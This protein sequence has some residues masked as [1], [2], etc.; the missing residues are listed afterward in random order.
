MTNCTK[1]I[2]SVTIDCIPDCHV[3]AGNYYEFNL[4][5]LKWGSL[6]TLAD[7]RSTV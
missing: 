4:T 7:T 6:I 5:W 2:L 3:T 1:A